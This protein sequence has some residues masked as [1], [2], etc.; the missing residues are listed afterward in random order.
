MYVCMH[1]IL[2]GV[3]LNS[4]NKLITYI[5]VCTFSALYFNFNF[6]YSNFTS[7]EL[8]FHL[9]FEMNDGVASS[10]VGRP[11]RWIVC[12]CFY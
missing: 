2:I 6:Q 4:Y 12:Y 8:H 9:P 10:G 11:V 3:E 1:S 5:Y 7:I